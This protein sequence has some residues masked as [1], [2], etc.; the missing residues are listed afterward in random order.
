MPPSSKG[1]WSKD[2]QNRIKIG[3]GNSSF[4]R[5]WP[6]RNEIGA[7]VSR[8]RLSLAIVINFL[9]DLHESILLECVFSCQIAD[10]DVFDLSEP[11]A[12]GVTHR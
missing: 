11:S 8:F 4:L 1:R 10:D 6:K 3:G 7:G 5:D 2:N 12:Q 9:F